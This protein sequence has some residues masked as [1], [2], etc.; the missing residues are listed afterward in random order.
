MNKENIF[1]VGGIPSKKAKPN[2]FTGR[3][4]AKDISAKIKPVNEK[5]Y[6]VTFKSGA[7]TKLHFHSGGQTLIATKGKGNL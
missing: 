5:I 2:Y 4:I 6:H 7:K 3:I 1:S